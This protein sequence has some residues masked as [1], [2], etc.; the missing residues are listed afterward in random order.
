LAGD[1]VPDQPRPRMAP[2]TASTSTMPAADPCHS[3]PF[4]RCPV[5][6]ARPLNMA[7]IKGS[8]IHASAG[9]PPRA[10]SHQ[11]SG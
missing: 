2:L 8:E 4:H 6:H 10:V 1:H 3:A 9:R 11:S 7:T 5:P